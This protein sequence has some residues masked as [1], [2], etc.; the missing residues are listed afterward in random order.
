[1][2][3]AKLI[4]HICI[5]Y[6]SIEYAQFVTTN[7]LLNGSLGRVYSTSIEAKGYMCYCPSK[8]SGIMYYNPSIV[9]DEKYIALVY[10]VLNRNDNSV[11]L[12]DTERIRNIVKRQASLF[13]ESSKFDYRTLFEEGKEC[14][15]DKYFDK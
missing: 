9:S 12:P 4:M 10:K 11:A 1:M 5:K 2:I 6:S 15:L 7:H 3:F 13:P 8:K 14:S